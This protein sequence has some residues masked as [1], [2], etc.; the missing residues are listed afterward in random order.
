MK[1]G[2]ILI[3]LTILLM[4]LSAQAAGVYRNFVWGVSPQDVRTF[5]KAIFYKQDDTSLFFLE[6][7]D[8]RRTLI[9]YDFKDDKLWRIRFD[10]VELYTPK[11]LVVFDLVMAEQDGLT[12]LF[13]PPAKEDLIWADKKYRDFPKFWHR[14]LAYEHLT[15]V[16]EWKNEQSLVRFEAFHNKKGSFYTIGY[17]IEDAAAAA[18]LEAA[19]TEDVWAAP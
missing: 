12:K 15:I 5:E 1:A 2:G 6:E 3:L 10:Y 7:K 11:S 16:S 17:T 13:G 8:G 19:K 9:R 14:A 4:P 18:K